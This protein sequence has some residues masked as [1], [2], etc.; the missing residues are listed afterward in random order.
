MAEQKLINICKDISD[1]G[2][3]IALAEICI[4]SNVGCEIQKPENINVNS[5][6]Y[7][8]DQGRYIIISEKN[9]TKNIINEAKKNNIY[10]SIIGNIKEKSFA[11]MDNNNKQE[12]SIENL[13]NLRN[14]WFNNY[15]KKK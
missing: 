8:E 13:S 11:V 7:G 12:I 1:G 15:L 3:A 14:N 2:L 9:N 6:L 10:I 4:M 5:W